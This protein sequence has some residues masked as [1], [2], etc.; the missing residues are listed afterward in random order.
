LTSEE[1]G[2]WI[3]RDSS[4]INSMNNTLKINGTTE[5]LLQAD[6]GETLEGYPTIEIKD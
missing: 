4:L 1:I 2:I 3:D 5:T 6:S